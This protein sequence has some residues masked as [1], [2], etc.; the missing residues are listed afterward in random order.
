[1]GLK[2]W[3]MGKNNNN[4]SKLFLAVL[5]KPIPNHVAIIMDGNG[6]WAR[7]RNM[8]RTAGHRQGVETLRD[9]I[10][11]SSR[12]GISYLSLY[13]FSTENWKRPESE[14]RYLMSLMVDFLQ[15]ETPELHANNVRIIMLGQLEG[16]PNNARDEICKAMKTTNDNT[17]LQVNIAINYGSRAEIVHAVQMVAK[18]VSLGRI[19][20]KDIDEELFAG[21]LDTK[22]IPDPELMIRTSGEY[23]LSNFLMF[24]SAY[25]ELI[26]TDKNLLWPD[27]TGERY[28]E[29]IAE[30][31]SRKRRFGGI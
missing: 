28:L 2:E 18:D 16:L 4:N 9:I 19:E 8:P 5:K 30:Y 15:V 1:M 22:G 25:T 13:A 23:R 24:Q 21:Y 31:Q 29:A 26:F 7:Q 6:R 10:Q 20:L 27:F 14:V 17:G 3:F 12:L 11:T